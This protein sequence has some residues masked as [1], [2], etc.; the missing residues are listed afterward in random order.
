MD[1]VNPASFV[2]YCSGVPVNV[3]FS[4]VGK[5]KFLKAWWEGILQSMKNNGEDVKDEDIVP[6]LHLPFSEKDM[7]DLINRYCTGL[8]INDFL[9]MNE[10]TTVRKYDNENRC[11]IITYYSE[12]HDKFEF[13]MLF[14]LISYDKA[15]PLSFTIDG[16]SSREYSKCIHDGDMIFGIHNKAYRCKKVLC[17]DGNYI[18]FPDVSYYFFSPTNSN[19]FRVTVTDIIKAITDCAENS[20]VSIDEFITSNGLCIM[21]NNLVKRD[22][23]KYKGTFFLNT[24]DCNFRMIIAQIMYNSHLRIAGTFDFGVNIA[25]YMV[26]LVET[27]V[28][29]RGEK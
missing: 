9:M 3:P 16:L 20:K 12:I 17:G 27:A 29:N 10:D 26:K 18:L 13:D 21:H 6:P 7:C 14:A 25:R 15:I 4:L 11:E 5:S 19:I 1:P 8:N 2:V 28:F 24:H 22:P 23:E